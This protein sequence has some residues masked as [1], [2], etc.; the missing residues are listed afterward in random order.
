MNPVHVR[1]AHL[2][3]H[4]DYF[5]AFVFLGAPK[6]YMGPVKREI[7]R[8]RWDNFTPHAQSLLND[9]TGELDASSSN[10]FITPL[11]S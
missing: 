11:S 3:V 10:D 6:Q 2:L 1:E 8:Y 5:A 7:C 9:S 4:S